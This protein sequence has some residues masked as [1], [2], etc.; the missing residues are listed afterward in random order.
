MPSGT[1]TGTREV[2]SDVVRAVHVNAQIGQ[3]LHLLLPH[4]CRGERGS[5]F[6]LSHRHILLKRDGD[7]V[8]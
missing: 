8:I 1:G 6:R 5:V 7:G 2:A 3:Q 4:G